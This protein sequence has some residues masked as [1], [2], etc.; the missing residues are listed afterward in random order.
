MEVLG[1]VLND[2]SCLSLGF[3]T[4]WSGSWVFGVGGVIQMSSLCIRSLRFLCDPRVQPGCKSHVRLT[5]SSVIGCCCESQTMSVGFPS[6]DS[7]KKYTILLKLHQRLHF[8][9]PQPGWAQFQWLPQL[10]YS[11]MLLCLGLPWK[12]RKLQDGAHIFVWS[13]CS[14]RSGTSKMELHLYLTSV[15]IWSE[16]MHLIKFFIYQ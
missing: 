1:Q 15:G 14:A 12:I 7:T 10:H 4:G 13:S 5:N 11:V 3:L 16:I 8:Q 9:F 2:W 6:Q